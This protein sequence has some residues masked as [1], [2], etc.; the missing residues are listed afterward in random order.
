MNILFDFARQKTQYTSENVQEYN[1]RGAFKIHFDTSDWVRL[2]L[3]LGVDLRGPQGGYK[4]MKAFVE[5]NLNV[6]KLQNFQSFAEI[7]WN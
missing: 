7:V 1:T 2:F 5:Q 6:W 4:K 3:L